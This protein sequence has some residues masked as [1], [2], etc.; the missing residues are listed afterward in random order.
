VLEPDTVS[1]RVLPLYDVDLRRH[2]DQTND[3]EA[4][5]TETDRDIPTYVVE[6]KIE[7]I[8]TLIVLPKWRSGVRQAAA[9]HPELLIS[10]SSART[11]ASQ[12][13]GNIGTLVREK[14][15]A[16][17]TGETPSGSGYTLHYRQTL[18]GSSC[19]P[20]IG[21]KDAMLLGRC[22]NDNATHTFWILSDPDLLNNHGLSQG[23]NAE[24]ALNWLPDLASG[25]GDIVLDLTT[26]SWVRRFGGADAAQRSWSD[27]ARFFAYPFSVIWWSLGIL[28]ALTFWR[29]W[30]RYGAADARSEEEKGPQ[31]SRLVSI[32]TKAR[33]LRLTGRDDALVR[34]HI[35]SRLEVL[36]D[37][38]LGPQR[39]RGSEGVDRLIAAIARRSPDLAAEYEPFREGGMNAGNSPDMLMRVVAQFDDLIERTHHEF[40]RT[41]RA[42]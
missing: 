34:T 40:G 10:E 21:T 29:A 39:S 35:D 38:L 30:R 3:P 28:G 18:S 11:I 27:L 15:V 6:R 33:L 24:A 32:D 17:V 23:G 12:I 26:S 37:D 41:G 36:A 2:G 1:L 31:A 13:E 14:D 19:T 4:V 42:R 20:M 9:V 16:E 25:D 8:P 5:M 22:R 7:T